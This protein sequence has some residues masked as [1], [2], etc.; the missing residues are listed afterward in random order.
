VTATTVRKR[1][2]L[3]SDGQR[4]RGR[5]KFYGGVGDKFPLPVGD[6]PRVLDVRRRVGNHIKGVE[7]VGNHPGIVL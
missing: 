6:V 3:T 1:C 2:A 4:R 7:N 5:A